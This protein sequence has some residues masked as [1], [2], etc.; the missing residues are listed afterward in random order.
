MQGLSPQLRVCSTHTQMKVHSALATGTG[1]TAIKSLE[2]ASPSFWVVVG[3]SN[4]R[5]EDGDDTPKWGHIDASLA[6]NEF[7]ADE[8]EERDWLDID[9]DAGWHRI[10]VN[11]SVPFH[12]RSAIP[13]SAKSL[14]HWWS[15]Y[16]RS[17]VSVIREKL[18]NPHDDQHFHY[19][20]F[21]LLW[22]PSNLTEEKDTGA[23]RDVY[24]SCI[25]GCS[26]RD[27]RLAGGAWV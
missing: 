24:I 26:P 14:H 17:L 25:S 1:I 4:F 10:P 6:R 23:W 16:H 13:G 27:T 9:E 19:E 3:N 15:S 21:T 11:I 18:A 20:L 5:P 8:G 2:K 7:D 12:G 22:T